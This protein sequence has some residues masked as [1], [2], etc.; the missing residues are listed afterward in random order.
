MDL[1]VQCGGV[2]FFGWYNVSPH[3]DQSLPSMSCESLPRFCRQ[4]IRLRS[5]ARFS[6]NSVLTFFDIMHV[7]WFLDSWC[8]NVRDTLFGN[9]GFAGVGTSRHRNTNRPLDLDSRWRRGDPVTSSLRRCSTSSLPMR[10][11]L[12][13]TMGFATPSTCSTSDIPRSYS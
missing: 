13:R 4:S 6:L 2:S 12:T 10:C 11:T 8:A 9:Q 5:D 1:A 3:L 7:M